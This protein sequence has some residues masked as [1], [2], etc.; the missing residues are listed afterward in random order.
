PT[1]RMVVAFAGY[2]AIGVAVSVL[3]AGPALV[4]VFTLLFILV[5]PG[6]FTILPATST[7]AV[8]ALLGL[9][10]SIAVLALRPGPRQLSRQ[11]PI[12][13][14]APIGNVVSLVA[15]AIFL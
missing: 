8:Y 9:A 3:A 15:V 14:L 7:L 5:W 13:W 2:V 11:V 1:G 4:S 6:R 12:V 10:A